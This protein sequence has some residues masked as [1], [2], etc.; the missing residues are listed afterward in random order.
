MANRPRADCQARRPG[1]CIPPHPLRVWPACQVDSGRRTDSQRSHNLGCST[2]PTPRAASLTRRS[3]RGAGAPN[4]RPQTPGQAFRGPGSSKSPGSGALSPCHPAQA[5]APKG[6]RGSAAAHGASPEQCNRRTPR[7][8][9]VPRSDAPRRAPAGAAASRGH[10]AALS[11]SH[12]LGRVLQ[13]AGAGAQAKQ[14][15]GM[16]SKWT[17]ALRR[18]GFR[19]FGGRAR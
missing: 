12:P 17:R 2:P 9:A 19:G 11:V 15:A 5:F 13:R 14:V 7:A 3:R 4:P 8:P 10:V 16:T 18:R 6:L 1:G